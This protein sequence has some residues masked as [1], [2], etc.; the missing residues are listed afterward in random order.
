MYK[1]TA[2]AILNL[3]KIKIIKNAI[4][5]NRECVIYAIC[6]L[7]KKVKNNNNNLYIFLKN[8]KLF[9]FIIII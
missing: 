7:T 8:I 5:V 2:K 6:H 3:S 4:I 9:V 1:K